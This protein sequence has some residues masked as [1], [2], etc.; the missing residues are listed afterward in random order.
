M[1]VE[2][3][4][5]YVALH[6]AHLPV[7]KVNRMDKNVVSYRLQKE[8]IYL[9]RIK[10]TA[11]YIGQ[12]LTAARRQWM[13]QEACRELEKQA[14]QWIRMKDYVFLGS[15]GRLGRYNFQ[16]PGFH[17]LYSR[18]SFYH[19]KDVILTLEQMELF[20]GMLWKEIQKCLNALFSYPAF[21]FR[22]PIVLSHLCMIVFLNVSKCTH[23]RYED[24]IIE[25]LVEY[26][27]LLEPDEARQ[28]LMGENLVQVVSE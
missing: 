10:H 28:Y 6:Q 3:F 7:S 19:S 16:I 26:S 15:T 11:I 8:G 22:V 25:Y 17:T 12:S 20:Q 4:S 2:R 18:H 9:L 23:T 24:E 5:F 27:L 21:N 1:D 14:K 13:S